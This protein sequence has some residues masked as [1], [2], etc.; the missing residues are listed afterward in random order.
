MV[1][2]SATGLVLIALATYRAARF[3]AADSLWAVPR[4]RLYRWAWDDEHPDVLD[5]GVGTFV[6]HSRGPVRS[7]VY[8]LATCQWCLGVWLA[9]GFYAAW[10]WGGNVS[11]AII[12][13]L[14]IAGGQG[15]LVSRG[16]RT[17]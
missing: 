11:H 8:E 15:F 16:D 14:A 6:P 1:V 10:R 3:F 5:D 2:P 7:Y 17:A 13:V 9:V 4:Q 12:A